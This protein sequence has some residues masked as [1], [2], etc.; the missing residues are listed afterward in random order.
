MTH[1]EIIKALFDETMIGNAPAVLELTNKALAEGMGPDTILFEALIPSLEEVGARFERG[2]YFVPEMLIAGKAMSGALNVLRPLLAETGAETVGTFLMGTVKGDV[3]DIGKNLVNIMLEGA[4]FKVID[5]GVQVAPEKF[6]AA[7]NEHQPDILGMSAFLTTTMPMFKVN[8]H[9]ITK[10]GLRDKVIIMVGGAPVTQEYADA[11]GADG[12][13][14]D[15]STAVRVA[16]DLIQK[17]RALVN[18]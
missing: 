1:D 14:S 2:D 18:A 3:H 5:I 8:I 6:I 4:G 10:A 7:I 13:A 12:F 17:K 15:A 11:V 16:K 9:E